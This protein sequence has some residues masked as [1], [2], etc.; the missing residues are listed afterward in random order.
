MA[1]IQEANVLWGP[2]SEELRFLP[3]GPTQLAPGRFLWVAIQHGPNSTVGSVNVFDCETRENRTFALP[4]R[5]GFAKPT[6]RQDTLVIGCERSLGL[7][8]LRT[9]QWEELVGG[10][11]SEVEGTIINDGTVYGSNIVFGTKDLEFSTPKAALYLYRGQDGQLVRLRGGQVCSNGKDVVDRGAGGLF[12]LDIDSPTRKLVEYPLDLHSARLGDPVAVIDFQDVSGVPDGMVLSPDE[13]SAIISFYNPEPAEYGCTRQY[14][15]L[16]GELEF[17]W[18]TPGSPRNTC[19]LLLELTDGTVALV[20]TTAVEHMPPEQL[21]QSP[22]AGALFIAPT[23]F[24]SAPHVPRFPVPA[25][26]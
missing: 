10:I 17:E 24:N 14:S 9:G 20:I 25:S 1:E 8:D 6:V 2:D 19:P 7:Y 12:L 3:E 22:N 4:G 11:D 23:R 18:R 26:H 5:P 16:N 21:E 15:L 13:Q